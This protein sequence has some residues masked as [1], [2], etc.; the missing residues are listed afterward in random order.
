M[1]K[2]TYAFYEGKFSN[3]TGEAEIFASNEQ[4]ANQIMGTYKQALN[5]KSYRLVMALPSSGALE[6]QRKVA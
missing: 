1:N 6:P 5:G 4:E 3:I 2:Y